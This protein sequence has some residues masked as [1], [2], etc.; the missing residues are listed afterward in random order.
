MELQRTLP[1]E[2]AQSMKRAIDKELARLDDRIEER[3]CKLND[4]SEKEHC[5]Q[6][7][8]NLMM[9]LSYIR[10]VTEVTNGEETSYA[11]TETDEDRARRLEAIAER[12]ER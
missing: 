3:W 2:I 12:C 7:K 8:E 6:E 11:V 5:I 10:C 4:E 1:K 9:A